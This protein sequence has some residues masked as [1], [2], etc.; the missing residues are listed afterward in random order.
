VHVAV[1]DDTGSEIPLDDLAMFP[2]ASPEE[3]QAV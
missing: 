2:T 1:V 3:S